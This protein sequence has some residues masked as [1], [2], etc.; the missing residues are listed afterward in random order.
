MGAAASTAIGSLTR[1][2]LAA[3]TQNTREMLDFIFHYLME[4]IHIRDFY[5]LSSPDECRRY[6]LV[7]ANRIHETFLSLDIVPSRTKA[8]KLY[9]RSVH[10]HVAPPTESE[11]VERQ[12]LCVVLAFFYVRIF[13]IFGALALT[14]V[15]DATAMPRVARGVARVFETGAAAAARPAVGRVGDVPVPFRGRPGGRLIGG[16]AVGG[17]V[18]GAGPSLGLFSFVPLRTPDRGPEDGPDGRKYYAIDT[19]DYTMGIEAPLGLLARLPNTARL[20]VY[21]RRAATVGGKK[22]S[23]AILTMTIAQKAGMGAQLSFENS[24]TLPGVA[25]SRAGDFKTHMGTA[26]LDREVGRSVATLDGVTYSGEEIGRLF[27]VFGERLEAYLRGQGEKREDR[28]DEVGIY[29]RPERTRTGLPLPLLAD[30]KVPMGMRM[31]SLHYA[32]TV[33]RPLPT[34]VSR[35]IQL[36]TTMPAGGMGPALTSVCDR[37]FLMEDSNKL[38]SG[39]PRPGDSMDT[40]PGEMALVQLFYDTVSKATRDSLEQSPGALKDYTTFMGLMARIYGTSSTASA[41][42]GLRPSD[43]KDKAMQ[44]VC[45]KLMEGKEAGALPIPDAVARSLMPYVQLLFKQQLAHAAAAGK[46]LSKL[47]AIETRGGVRQIRLNPKLLDGGF[48][49]L[50][51]ITAET[52]QLLTAYYSRC[53]ETYREGVK[54]LYKGLAPAAAV[55]PVAA[56]AAAPAAAPKKPLLSEGAMAGLRMAAPTAREKP[57]GVELKAPTAAATTAPAAR[58]FIA[59]VPALAPVRPK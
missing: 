28:R 27:D 40:S 42:T 51:V 33:T 52:R 39:A 17:A 6:I 30:E 58:P 10:D 38:R 11:K 50:E 3:K 16:G 9:Y 46:I 41:A 21:L 56:A 1:E 12:T 13:Q 20:L 32:L 15:D 53:E 24:I 48:P 54:T 14:L 18:G 47:F 8:G 5:R 37:G 44:M 49:T 59:G 36:L 35:A 26:T 57:V 7:L 22:V 25:V 29:D 23:Y 31:S 19:R 45:S 43:I 4:D 34:C 2:Q 55:T